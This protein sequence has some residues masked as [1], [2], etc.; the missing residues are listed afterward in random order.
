[1][2]GKSVLSYTSGCTSRLITL[3]LDLMK[4]G[5]GKEEGKEINAFSTLAAG[6]HITL[7]SCP[8]M[9]K[10]LF[11]LNQFT[12]ERNSR[13]LVTGI[14]RGNLDTGKVHYSSLAAV[15]FWLQSLG[16]CKQE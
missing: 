8:G 15:V 7:D 3:T 10:V 11:F 13:G 6:V 16:S 2:L 5:D 1:M 4:S 9:S 14:W 12:K